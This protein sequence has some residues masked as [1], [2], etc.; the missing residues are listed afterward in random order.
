VGED[1]ERWE[2][3]RFEPELCRAILKGYLS[4]ARDFLTENDH[5][6]LYDATRLIAFELGL[7]YLTDHLEGNVYFKTRFP[8]HNLARALVQFKLTE[9]IESQEAVIRTIIGDR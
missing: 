6:Y 3:V 4:L 1:P 8:E 5:E 9:S 7:R 2:M